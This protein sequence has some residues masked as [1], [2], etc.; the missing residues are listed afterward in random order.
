MSSPKVVAF[1]F[2]PSYNFQVDQL[3]FDPTLRE[4]RSRFRWVKAVT[5]PAKRLEE[6]VRAE[7]SAVA[8][9]R[10]VGASGT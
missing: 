1:D 6:A 8:N 4:I 3:R 2:A 10:L 5:A 9:E 7:A